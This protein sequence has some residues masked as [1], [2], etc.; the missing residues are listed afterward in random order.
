MHRGW[1]KLWRK[2]ENSAVWDDNLLRLWLHCLIHANHADKQVVVDRL[3]EPIVVKR[4]AFITGRY[5]LHKALYPKKRNSNP[6]PNTTWRRLKTL[7]KLGNLGIR[8]G[9]RYSMITIT[10]YDTY[11]VTDSED[12]QPN[13]Q[14]TGSRRA[15]DGHKQE[16]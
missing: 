8:T 4:G 7:E 13:G 2:I 11:N 3:A 16:Q 1:V 6:S 9:S 12:G 10:E 5:A 14:Q 15:A